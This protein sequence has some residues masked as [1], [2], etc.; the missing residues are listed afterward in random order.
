MGQNI[1]VK[2]QGASEILDYPFDFIAAPAVLN[3][4]DEQISSSTFTVDS[5]LTKISDSRT[6][7]NAT[8]W[9]TGG[10]PGTTYTVTC[11]VETTQARTYEQSMLLRITTT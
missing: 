2:S 4:P 11:T 10:D 3:W 5:G 9:L 8:V 6:T 7:S 1:P